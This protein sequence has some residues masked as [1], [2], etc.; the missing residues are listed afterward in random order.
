MTT[1]ERLYIARLTRRADKLSPELA[2][3]ELAAYELIRQ[4]LSEAELVRAI[5]TGQ[6]D[7]LLAEIL[8]DENLDRTLRSLRLKIDQT[9]IDSASAEAARG[10]PSSL[11]GVFD[12][13]APHV[14]EAVRRFDIRPTGALKAEVRQ[15]VR[16]VVEDGLRAGKGPRVVASRIYGA[17]GLAPNQQRAIERFRA[18]LLAGDRAAL[19]RSLGQDI[20]VTADGNA[21][22]RSGHAGGKGL[23]DLQLA[24]LDRKL[25]TEPLSASV[26]DTYV[27]SYR[28]RL[29]AWNTETHARTVTL[30]AQKAGNQLAWDDAIERGVVAPE[31]LAVEWVAV[32]GPGGD[33]RNR[34]EH[35]AM[36]GETIPFGGTFSNGQKVPG[37]SDYNCRCVARVK[38]VTQ[39][40]RMAA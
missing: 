23:T 7:R 39:V 2:R 40:L 20:L 9:L 26:V 27:E 5:E 12:R 32:G 25:G 14:I 1:A 3:R 19:S 4:S 21:I 38:L 8:S 22:R 31:Q 33:G 24:R 6:V 28:K 16:Q 11:A 10:L 15:T 17:I 35:L 13:L 29:V 37:E 18:E 30:Q 36:H 34:P